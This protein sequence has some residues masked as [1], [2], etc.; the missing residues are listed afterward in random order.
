MS[1]F[2]GVRGFNGSYQLDHAWHE[3]EKTRAFPHINE[4]IFRGW[5][6]GRFEEIKRF[7]R[8]STRCVP[9]HWSDRKCQ[10]CKGRGWFGRGRPACPVCNGAKYEAVFHERAWRGKTKIDGPF[11][12]LVEE[13][14]RLSLGRKAIRRNDYLNK[15]YKAA[16]NTIWVYPDWI[17][18]I[19]FDDDVPKERQKE[20][21]D[22]VIQE[23]K[24][25]Q[26]DRKVFDVF[27]KGRADDSCALEIEVTLMRLADTF[28]VY[29]PLTGEYTAPKQCAM[30]PKG[31]FP[32]WRIS[33]M[34]RLGYVARFRNRRDYENYYCVPFSSK[35]LKLIDASIRRC[36]KSLGEYS[37]E[38]IMA[39]I[40]QKQIRTLAA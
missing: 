21:K 17:E 9:A 39:D 29:C 23:F 24:F 32:W 11:Y 34:E 18:L 30:Y 8:K 37:E 2:Y 35:G 38:W 3:V 36:E 16:T 31:F 14:K 4:E 15:Y 5:V 6:I 28:G 20:L 19:K 25:Q 22:R 13:S 12:R 10:K 26:D 33:L 7:K 27:K 40:L 1:N